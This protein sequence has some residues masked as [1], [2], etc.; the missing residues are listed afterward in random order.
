VE[1]TTRAAA[2]V[3]QNPQRRP[4]RRIATVSVLAPLVAFGALA[5]SATSAEA[6]V[7][8]TGGEVVSW[9]NGNSFSQG[10]GGV[11]DVPA[12]A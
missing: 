5:V 7:P 10:P 2:A 9:G 11:T 6:A 4:W 3:E 8:A 12:A 1:R